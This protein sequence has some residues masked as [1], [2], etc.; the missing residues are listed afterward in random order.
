[1]SPCYELRAYPWWRPLLTITAKILPTGGQRSRDRPH[2]YSGILLPGSSRIPLLR[3]HCNMLSNLPCYTDLIIC[4]G[5]DVDDNR[6]WYDA[7][8][9]NPDVKAT[10]SRIAIVRL[11]VAAPS[12]SGFRARRNFASLD[13]RRAGTK[14]CTHI[15]S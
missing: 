7:G 9:G 11:W 13:E 14:I 5:A 1:M 4:V 8:R 15:K 10:G 12:T 3:R 6:A 2:L